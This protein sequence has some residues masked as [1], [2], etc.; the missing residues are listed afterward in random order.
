MRIAPTPIKGEDYLVDFRRLC[1]VPL[2]VCVDKKSVSIS[3]DSGIEIGYYLPTNEDREFF[4]GLKNPV[5]HEH[6]GSDGKSIF[7]LEEGKR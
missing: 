2:V 1:D 5:I 6:T 7:I 4:T 3:N